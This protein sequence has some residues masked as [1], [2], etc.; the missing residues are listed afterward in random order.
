MLDGSGQATFR[1]ILGPR[2]LG[3]AQVIERW[4]SMAG[5]KREM[6][7]VLELSEL[8]R[9]LNIGMKGEFVLGT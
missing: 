1:G 5:C 7:E 8:S 3:K 6:E 9:L 4:V 2:L